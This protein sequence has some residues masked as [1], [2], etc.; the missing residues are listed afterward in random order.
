MK[1]Y[2]DALCIASKIAYNLAWKKCKTILKQHLENIKSNSYNTLKNQPTLKDSDDCTSVWE[3]HYTDGG[4]SF[5]YCLC[6]G[7]WGSTTCSACP[8][9]GDPC[10]PQDLEEYIPYVF[11]GTNGTS[12]CDNTSCYY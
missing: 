11:C 8:T 1:D 9:D 2:P 10:S 7:N 5:Y 4:T 12:C 6:D 3:Y